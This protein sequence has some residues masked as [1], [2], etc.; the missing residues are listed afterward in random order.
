MSDVQ[1]DV[2]TI[3][4]QPK[5]PAQQ[6]S[7]I[8]QA[9][10]GVS[11]SLRLIAIGIILAFLSW[12][13]SVVIAVLLSVLIAYFL[14]PFVTA[15]EHIHIPRSLGALVVLLAATAGIGAAGY[16]ALGRLDTFVDAWP[17]YNAVLKR[18]VAIIDKKLSN[19]DQQVSELTPTGL[20]ATA[21][22][23]APATVRVE[24]AQ[25]VRSL[26]LRGLGSL[27]SVLFMW[28]FA[29]FLIFFML[30]AKRRLWRSTLEL[31]PETHRYAAR[32]AL[33]QVSR[34]LR[35]YVAGN[36]LI[37]LILSAAC[38]LF[39]WAIH[40][41]YP[42]VIGVAAGFLN[43]IPYIGTVLSWIP[44]FVIGLTHWKTAGPFFGV[45]GVLTGLHLIAQNL[46]MPA[47]VGRRVHLNA[48]AVTVALLFWGWLWGAAGLILAIPITAVLK[49]VCDHVPSWQPAGRWLGS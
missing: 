8:K 1:T 39:F 12:A 47:I 23:R 9:T 27:Y 11:A 38:G 43:L 31:F 10:T 45:A 28:T 29:P 4:S 2:Q 5:A 42:V 6:V 49:V 15:L 46:L 32:E 7:V 13:S 44:P 25:P 17:S 22:R 18:E 3:E 14:D 35:S 33:D 30:A 26:L 19:V 41:D 34:M 37:A 24:E 20:S 16:A 21:Q 48:V 36:L 40:L